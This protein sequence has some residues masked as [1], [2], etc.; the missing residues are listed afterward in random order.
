MSS[1]PKKIGIACWGG[2]LC[3]LVAFTS[4]GNSS[5]GAR[6]T[7][8]DGAPELYRTNC[9]ECHGV[10]GRARTAKGKRTGATDF[11][12][13]DWNTDEARGIRI[14]SNGKSSMPRFKGKLTAAEIRSVFRHVLKFRD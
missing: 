3:L 4:A 10:D 6:R 12:G 7:E 14:I 13:T 8:A 1:T 2:L 11:T 5:S 9:A